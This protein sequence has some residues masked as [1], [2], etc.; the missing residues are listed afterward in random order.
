M[1]THEVTITVDPQLPTV[2]IVRE[3]DA[4]PAQVYRAHVD[5][6][7]FAQWVG[8]HDLV[9]EVDHWD[10]R[11]GGSWRYVAR[12][13][14]EEHWFRGCFHE[15]R[16]DERIVQTFTYEGFPDSVSLEFLDFEP[17]PG[18]RCRLHAVSV[19]DSLAARDAFVASGMESGVVAGY[20]KLDRLLS[21]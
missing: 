6:T 11:T 4:T 14:R 20:E 21:A 2:E 9:T 7:L 12:R 18:G 17:L 10:P 19:V 16:P 5:P 8:P 1:T 3:F 13:H 15:V